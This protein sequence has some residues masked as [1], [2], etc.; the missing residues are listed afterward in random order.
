MRLFWSEKS[1]W[2]VRTLAG[3][4][5]WDL[6]ELVR[7]VMLNPA[8]RRLERIEGPIAPPAYITEFPCQHGRDGLGLPVK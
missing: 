5:G 3:S 2:T 1:I 4:L 8:L 7:T 6:V